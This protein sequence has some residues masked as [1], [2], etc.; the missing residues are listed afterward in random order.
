VLGVFLCVTRFEASVLR[1]TAMAG[2]SVG[3]A[4]FGSPVDG[5]R[6]L[7]AAVV[8]L[9]LVDPFLV[10]SL[11]FQLS[12]L[13]TA[14]IVWLSPSLS[15]RVPGPELWRVAVATTV[16]AQLAVSP[17]L[18]AVFGP[19]PLAAL[20]A[21]LVAGP[22]SGPLMMW[23]VTAGLIAGIFEPVAEWVHVPSAALVSWIR[24]VA[25]ISATA[26][27]VMLGLGHVAGLSA[28]IG[29]L[30]S[31]ARWARY[32]SVLFVLGVVAH[33]G[34]VVPELPAGATTPIEGVTVYVDE[35]VVVVLDNPPRVQ[36]AIEALR[37]AAVRRV[38]VVI[39]TDGDYSDAMVAIALSERYEPQMIL[40]PPLH[41]VPHARSVPEGQTIAVAGLTVVVETDGDSH[42]LVVSG[43]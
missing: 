2:F 32:V 43:W 24:G 42:G 35:V 29:L 41:R 6:A 12:A 13:A 15:A 28:G 3:A 11:A 25:S 14:G 19:V 36:A 21:N 39:A 1:A 34:W 31:G 26:P 17:L 40:A 18:V 22:A 37:R 30:M 33:A 38:D 16:S 4:V 9:L 5:R 10:R 20:P 23:G 8:A 27:P 7:S